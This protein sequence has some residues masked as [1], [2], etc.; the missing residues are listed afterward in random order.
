MRLVVCVLTGVVIGVSALLWFEGLLAYLMWRVAV[1][2]WAIALLMSMA[3]IVLG[4]WL[5]RAVNIYLRDMRF[6]RTRALL[7][8]AFLP[9]EDS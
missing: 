4:V 2:V 5:T 9:P 1:P 7:R 3:N 6:A 8:E